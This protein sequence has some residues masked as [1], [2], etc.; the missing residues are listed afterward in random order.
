MLRKWLTVGALMMALLMG[1]SYNAFAD[2]SQTGNTVEDMFKKQDSPNKGQD[3]KGD[4]SKPK[5]AAVAKDT[6]LFMVFLKLIGA[7]IIILLLIYFLYRVVSKRTKSYQD[8]GT[9]KNIGGVSVGANRS[10]QLVRVGKE[11]LVIGVGESVQ[12]LKEVQDP[13]TLEALLKHEEPSAPLQVN[14]KKV[15]SWTVDKTLKATGGQ[16]QKDSSEFKKVLSTHLNEVKKE[17]QEQ[18]KAMTQKASRD[19]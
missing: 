4:S 6:N 5:T 12:L 10:I 11:V 16:N 7:L 1:Q 3:T 17:R 8:Y 2:T 18:I 9:I 15:I 19:E 14:M 13:E